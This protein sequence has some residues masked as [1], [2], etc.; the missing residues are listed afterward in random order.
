MVKDKGLIEKNNLNKRVEQL[1]QQVE[2]KNNK[3]AVS[4]FS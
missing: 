2:E 1:E 4:I 3:I